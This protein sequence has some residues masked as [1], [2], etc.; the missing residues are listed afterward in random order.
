MYK[1]VDSYGTCQ[2]CWTWKEALEW[3]AACSPYAVVFNRFTGKI[4]A[5]RVQQR[6]NVLSHRI[7]YHT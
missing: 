4:L 1:I 5:I 3:L 2:V 7:T 6:I